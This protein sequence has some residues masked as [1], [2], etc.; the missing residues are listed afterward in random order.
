M[1]LLGSRLTIERIVKILKIG[2]SGEA[3]II[4][5]QGVDVMKFKL[6]S[7]TIVSIDKR[8]MIACQQKQVGMSKRKPQQCKNEVT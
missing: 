2:K 7:G 4:Y 5:P 3:S 6:A 8:I 1:I